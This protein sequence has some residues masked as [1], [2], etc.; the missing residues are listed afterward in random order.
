MI[1]INYASDHAVNVNYQDSD[2]NSALHHAINTEDAKLVRLLIN[3][4]AD[5][6]C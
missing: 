5:V 1:D 4:F 6:R 3:N 2:G